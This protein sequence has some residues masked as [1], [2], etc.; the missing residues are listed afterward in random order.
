MEDILRIERLTT[1]R[2]LRA[3]DAEAWS[4]PSLCAGW[5]VRHVLAHMVTP[6]EVSL[7]QMG[8]TVLRR[9]S[10]A[11]AMD[12]WARRLAERPV[13]DLLDVLE[14]NAASTWHAPGMPLA[15]PLTDVLVHTLDIRWA[16]DVS[17]TVDHVDPAHVLPS[18]EFVT[19]PSAAGVFVPKGRCDG[20]RV[21]A[22]DVDFAHGTGP[23][24][25]GPALALLAGACGRAPALDLLSGD[26]LARWR[27]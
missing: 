18:L 1:V 10:L 5:T 16:L 11:G 26:G 6:F 2:H 20:V 8:G 24:I 4:R 14:R 15:S 3:L 19:T 21:V 13:G 22:D 23:T 9:R 27:G 12:A 25:S 17:P 7:W